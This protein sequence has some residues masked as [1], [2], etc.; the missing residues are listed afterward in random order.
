MTSFGLICFICIL[1]LFIFR[2]WLCTY[3]WVHVCV[4][5]HVVKQCLAGGLE[6]KLQTGP[7]CVLAVCQG[8]RAEQRKGWRGNERVEGSVQPCGCQA[9]SLAV[10]WSELVCYWSSAAQSENREAHNRPANQQGVPERWH[11]LCWKTLKT[12]FYLIY[13]PHT[14]A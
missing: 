12:F 10:R 6:G 3:V 13:H 4:W 2:S 9:D 14:S 1:P 11:S 7:V 5:G 8:C